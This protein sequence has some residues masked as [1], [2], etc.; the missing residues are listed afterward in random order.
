MNHELPRRMGVRTQH[1]CEWE[2]RQVPSLLLLPQW[3]VSTAVP[4]PGPTGHT[5]VEVAMA[6]GTAEL[7]QAHAQGVSLP[8]PGSHEGGG[9]RPPHVL[10]APQ[11]RALPHSATLIQAPCPCRE[12]TSQTGARPESW[13]PGAQTGQG[14]QLSQGGL[15]PCSTLFT[16]RRCH[17]TLCRVLPGAARGPSL[18]HPN[19]RAAPATGS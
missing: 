8:H 18:C 12:C 6:P 7:A 17:R 19:P 3:E 16:C 13:W 4:H 5:S 14:E 9:R 10:L 15:S 1:P 11:E 2:T